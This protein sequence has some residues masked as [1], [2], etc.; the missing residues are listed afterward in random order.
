[1]SETSDDIVAEILAYA[2]LVRDAI[3]FSLGIPTYERWAERIEQLEAQLAE[4]DQTMAQLTDVLRKWRAEHR[5]CRPA[6]WGDNRCE[7]CKTTDAILPDLRAQNE[8]N[9]KG[10]AS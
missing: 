1:M 5:G 3:P 9:K 2:A 8:R 10:S 6:T 7:L 4:R